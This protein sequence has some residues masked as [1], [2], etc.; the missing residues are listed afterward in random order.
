MLSPRDLRRL[1]LEALGSVRRSQYRV[2]AMVRRA[3]R[4]GLG[5]GSVGRLL[6]CEYV[7]ERVALRLETLYVAGF[8]TKGSLELPYRLLV[9]AH[10][11]VAGIHPEL[12]YSV[13]ELLEAIERIQS[14][15]PEA[16]EAWGLGE[17][18]DEEVRRVL[19]EARS[20]VTG[21]RA[22]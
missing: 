17:G 22:A 7:L 10:S 6:A 8:A 12:Y 16:P 14:A 18:V 13:S 5:A 3:G 4:E 1:L 20:R 2:R 19:E 9:E 21:G 15:L 11:M